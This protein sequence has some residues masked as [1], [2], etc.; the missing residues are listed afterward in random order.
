MS[1]LKKIHNSISVVMHKVMQHVKFNGNLTESL[2]VPTE[3][4]SI[5]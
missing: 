5:F 4:K 1:Q 2:N 3:V